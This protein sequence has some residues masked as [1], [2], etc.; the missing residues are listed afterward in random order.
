MSFKLP[1]LLGSSEN[2]HSVRCSFVMEQYII[3]S[4]P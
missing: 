1:P 4:V 3:I 2:I